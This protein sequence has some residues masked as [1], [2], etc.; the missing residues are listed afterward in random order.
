MH[1]WIVGAAPCRY[2]PSAGPQTRVS[3]E[4][5]MNQTLAKVLYV[6][7]VTTFCTFLGC[8]AV[9]AHQESTPSQKESARHAGG[10]SADENFIRSAGEANIAE[11]KMGELA[12]EKAQAPE[13][14]NLAK[15]IVEDHT[16]AQEDLKQ[17]AQ[18]EG[19]NLPTDWSRKDALTHERLSK[20]SGPQF[21]REYT[22][23]M[24]KDHQKDIS[25]FK[26]A[27]TT[28][29]NP[30]SKEYAEKELPT[31]QSHLELAQHA[32][33]HVSREGVTKGKASSSPQR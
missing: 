25:E 19:I 26:R 28:V 23:E 20:L 11:V 1:R 16:K 32:Q 15:R 24:V 12:E 17:I 14:K 8:W 10:G 31:L 18:K 4:G 5:T 9:L 30:A 33:S 27:E 21:D 6:A 29:K 22:E 3:G 13:V 7:G 2:R